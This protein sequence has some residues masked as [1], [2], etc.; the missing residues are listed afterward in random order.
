MRKDIDL[1][2]DLH[3]GFLEGRKL[4]SG[5]DVELRKFSEEMRR[6]KTSAE[7]SEIIEKFEGNNLRKRLWDATNYSIAEAFD[8]ILKELMR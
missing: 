3:E 4:P 1:Y 8:G 6:S 7:R 5:L 2:K